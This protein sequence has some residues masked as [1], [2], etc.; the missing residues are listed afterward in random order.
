MTT[1]VAPPPNAPSCPPQEVSRLR[2]TARGLL[3]D[4][5]RATCVKFNLP[6]SQEK[7]D[8]ICC[9]IDR[10]CIRTATM[11]YANVGIKLDSRN[12]QHVRYYAE[13]IHKMIAALDYSPCDESATFVS[14]ILNCPLDEISTFPKYTLHDLCPEV[15]QHEKAEIELRRSRKVEPKVSKE[16][17]CRCGGNDTIFTERTILRADEPTSL[18]V[19]C[20][21][22]HRQWTVT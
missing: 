1:T 5:L 10:G 15:G 8:E 12:P 2:K 6:L 17:H 4:V 16:F 20:I 9:E 7:A 13:L 3:L 21:H 14:R 22:C 19:Q 18:C 11:Y